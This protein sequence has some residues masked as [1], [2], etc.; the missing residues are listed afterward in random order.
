MACCTDIVVDFSAVQNL[1][2]SIL[3]KQ[4]TDDLGR[5][6]N[7]QIWMKFHLIFFFSFVKSNNKLANKL[8]KYTMATQSASAEQSSTDSQTVIG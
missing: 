2:M 1:L 6:P 3:S 4:Q 5:Y 8:L 7:K